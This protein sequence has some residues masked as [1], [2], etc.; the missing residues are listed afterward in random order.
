MPEETT[1]AKSSPGKRPPNAILRYSGMA[2]QMM[3]IIV[4]GA[5]GGIWLDGHFET[6]KPW[7]TGGLTILS[8]IIAM[9]SAVKDLLRDGTSTK[10]D[11]K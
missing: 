6:S 9:Y 3:V 10:K 7:F 2:M 4:A 1:G 8:V 11:S 5:L